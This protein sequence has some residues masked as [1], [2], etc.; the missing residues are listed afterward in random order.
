MTVTLFSR[1]LTEPLFLQHRRLNSAPR[2]AAS[3]QSY[4]PN[5]PRSNDPSPNPGYPAVLKRA[6][7]DLRTDASRRTGVDRRSIPSFRV[8]GP[9]GARQRPTPAG[10]AN[11]SASSDP[12]NVQVNRER[13][14]R[15]QEEVQQSFEAIASELGRIDELSLSLKSTSGTPRRPGALHTN[16]TKEELAQRRQVALNLLNE[17]HS[18]CT[19]LSYTG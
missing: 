13:S 9:S 2:A 11:A 12:Q 15:I 7:T 4:P 1:A 8:P 6:D 10:Y 14:Q 18:R 19:A 5:R 17:L 16:V 3:S